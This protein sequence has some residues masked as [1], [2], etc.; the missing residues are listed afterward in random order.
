MRR[1]LSGLFLLLG[2]VLAS[3]AFAQQT[4]EQ[5]AGDVSEVDRAAQ[6]PLRERIA[7]VSGKLFSKGGRF[8]ISP[9]VTLSLADP[10][11]T[12]YVFGGAL[13]YHLIDSLAIGLRGGYSLPTISSAAQ[14]CTTETTGTNTVRGCRSPLFEEVNGRAPGQIRLLAGADLQWAPIYGKVSLLAERFIHFD[15]YAVGGVAAVQYIGP[16]ATNIGP[17]LTVGGNVGVGMRF[18]VNSWVSV[19]AE[20]RDLIYVENVQPVPDTQLRNQLLFELG[21]SF[22]LP[23][24]PGES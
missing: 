1:A 10:F 13:T 17:N 20:L 5:E 4:T 3:S 14:I 6:G 15:L 18:F 21:V 16:T 7:P 9:S 11:F 19:R 12:K 23:T 8:E 24:T 22:F 2:L